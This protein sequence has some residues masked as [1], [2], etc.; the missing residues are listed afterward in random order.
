MINLE[1][2]HPTTLGLYM[3]SKKRYI[4]EKKIEQRLT[5]DRFTDFID[6]LMKYFTDMQQFASVKTDIDCAK[7]TLYHVDIVI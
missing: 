3:F 5:D 6:L 2:H 4:I 1:Q 7:N